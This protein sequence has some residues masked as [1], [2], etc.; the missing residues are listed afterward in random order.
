MSGITSIHNKF[1]TH[2]WCRLIKKG[3]MKLSMLRQ[4]RTNPRMSAYIDLEGEFNYERMLFSPPGM[5]VII[6]KKP[7]KRSLWACH[8]KVG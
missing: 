8:G 3:E 2:L 4:C 6:H 5:K 1:P 7:N